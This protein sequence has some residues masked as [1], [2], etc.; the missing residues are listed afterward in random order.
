MTATM[1]TR[2]TTRAA[3]AAAL[4]LSALLALS[5]CGGG[6]DADEKAQAEG[7]GDNAGA[8]GV[9]MN[10][11]ENRT[12]IL[13]IHDQDIAILGY[14]GET[15]EEFTTYFDAA[16]SG[17][18]SAIKDDDG[19]EDDDIASIEQGTLNDTQSQML[20]PSDTGE[21]PKSVS[22]NSPDSGM[23]TVGNDG[24]YYLPKDSDEGKQMF[25]VW[26]NAQCG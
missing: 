16:K 4:A 13:V 20:F 19:D 7:V 8:Q 25:D 26:K 5:A 15:C 1:T 14:K 3:S 21:D 6:D 18:F 17:D 22:V 10:H 23:I 2:T 24:E 12:D 11:S 9:Y